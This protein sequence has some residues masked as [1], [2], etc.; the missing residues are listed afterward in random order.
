M[1]KAVL[2]KCFFI[3]MSYQGVAPRPSPEYECGKRNPLYPE[4][5]NS[6]VSIIMYITVQ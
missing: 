5:G 3:D 6:F 4:Q 1:E 2:I